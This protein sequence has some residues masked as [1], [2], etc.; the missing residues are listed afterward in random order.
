MAWN[1]RN[2]Q[3]RKKNCFL[4]FT[5][6]NKQIVKFLLIWKEK[7]V[8]ENQN[9][10]NKKKCN[11]NVQCVY[12]H[13]LLLL[14]SYNGSTH[15]FSLHYLW[16]RYMIEAFWKM[17]RFFCCIIK[18]PSVESEKVEITWNTKW[19]GRMSSF[20]WMCD[21]RI[22]RWWLMQTEQAIHRIISEFLLFEFQL[23]IITF[24]FQF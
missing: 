17:T 21:I 23:K 11:R 16:N 3:R 24:N 8:K 18:F 20:I 5:F 2:F 12:F 4:F 15:P 1:H 7:V 13:I 14:S 19:K 9:K 6:K 22:L 10:R